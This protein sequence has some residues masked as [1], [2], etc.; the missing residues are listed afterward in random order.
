MKMR[1]CCGALYRSKLARNILYYK[2]EM[3]EEVN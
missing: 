3:L 1:L 2:F